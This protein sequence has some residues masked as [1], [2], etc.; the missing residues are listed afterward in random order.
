MEDRGARVA[1]QKFF[2]TRVRDRVELVDQV[3]NLLPPGGFRTAGADV[4]VSKI[5]RDAHRAKRKLNN[6]RRGGK[7]APPGSR[8]RVCPCGLEGTPL[9]LRQDVRN[10][11]RVCQNPCRLELFRKAL[12]MNTVRI[13]ERNFP[14]FVRELEGNCKYKASD[15]SSAAAGSSHPCAGT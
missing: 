5:T 7:P 15:F 11:S 13:V 10:R 3:T 2:P 12:F 6:T 14:F 9:R 4:Q 8:A 1:L